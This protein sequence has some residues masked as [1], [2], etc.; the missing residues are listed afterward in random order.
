MSKIGDRTSFS[1][2]LRPETRLK[3]GLGSET[4]RAFIRAA[5][6][7]VQHGFETDHSSIA[8]L[9]RLASSVIINHHHSTHPRLTIHSLGTS[10][11]RLPVIAEVLIARVRIA[12]VSLSPHIFSKC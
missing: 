5:F 7:V 3:P 8:D 11:Y 9:H 4:S 6:A 2:E 1:N 12:K 10:L